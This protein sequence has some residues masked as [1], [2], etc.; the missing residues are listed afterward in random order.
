VAHYDAPRESDFLGC[1]PTPCNG[2]DGVETI[3]W[4][5]VLGRRL[6]KHHAWLRPTG[7]PYNWLRD[8]SSAEQLG[9]PFSPVLNMIS[10]RTLQ[11]LGG[12]SSNASYH[13]ESDHSPFSVVADYS[14][15]SPNRHTYAQLYDLYGIGANEL[16]EL[17]YALQQV[18][19]L[20]TYLSLEWL[21][22]VWERDL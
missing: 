11:I 12:A 13:S 10:L 7:N 2:P 14:G 19:S 8:I 5:P 15:A 18:T 17:H 6:Y 1:R 4:S 3:L 21:N 22:G 9:F 16:C 20:P